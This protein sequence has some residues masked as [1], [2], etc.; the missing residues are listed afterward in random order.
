MI[1]GSE[2]DCVGRDLRSVRVMKGEGMR[3]GRRGVVERE[4][5]RGGGEMSKRKPPCRGGRGV[6]GE[7]C[8]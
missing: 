3:R 7:V 1:T 8:V 4:E 5:E 2:S 6:G